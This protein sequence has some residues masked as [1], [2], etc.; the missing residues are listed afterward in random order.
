M[1][2]DSTT[3]HTRPPLG[4]LKAAA[5]LLL[6]LSVAGCATGPQFT[7]PEAPPPETGRVY[8]YRP[9]KLIGGGTV[10]HV[11][12]DASKDAL[13]LPNGSWIKLDLAPGAH[14]I[15]IE[16]FF[17][18]MQCGSAGLNLQA[19]QVAYVADH[20]NTTQGLNRLYVSCSVSRQTDDQAKPEITGLSETRKD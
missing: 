10:H 19:G 12:V 17:G 3:D 16:D 15:R 2:F 13:S 7:A 18:V 5:W 9:F 8:L 4:R 20:V 11:Y 14:S 1:H 6:A